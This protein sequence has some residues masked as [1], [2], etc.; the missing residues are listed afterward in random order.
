MKNHFEIINHLQVVHF[1]ERYL[2][3]KQKMDLL[4]DEYPLIS[5]PQQKIVIFFYIL[6]FPPRYSEQSTLRECGENTKVSRFPK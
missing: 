5:K 4:D 1:I 2:S 3:E 6:Q